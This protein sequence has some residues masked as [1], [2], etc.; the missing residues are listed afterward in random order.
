MVSIYILKDPINNEVRYVGKTVA[1]PERRLAQHIYQWKRDNIQYRRV[2]SWILSL[3]KKNKL[4]LIEV[5]D[6]VDE[7]IWEQAEIGY[8]R[9]FKSF[10]CRLTNHSLGGVGCHGMKHKK[11]SIIKRLDTQKNSNN[12]KVSHKRQSDTMKK[13]I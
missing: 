10:G 12:W 6:E 9:L 4:P 1:K 5:I 11:D 13:S 3:Y 8:I 2:D 7:S